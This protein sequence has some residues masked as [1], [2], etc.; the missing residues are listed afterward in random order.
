MNNFIIGYL[1]GAFIGLCID[2]YVKS[3]YYDKKRS[4]RIYV[5]K[6]CYRLG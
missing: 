2:W 1:I 5:K 4:P 6:T 3:K